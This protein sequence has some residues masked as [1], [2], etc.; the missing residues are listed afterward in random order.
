LTTLFLFGFGRNSWPWIVVLW[1][2][3]AIVNFFLF[4]KVP[5][6]PPIPEEHRQGMKMLILKPF[7]IVAFLA[8]LAGGASELVMSQWSSAFMEKAMLLPKVVG[9]VAGMTMFALMLG[10][11]R[12]LYGIYGTK[13]NVIRM[14]MAGSILAIACYL[15]VAFSPYN[16]LSLI[17]CAV[18]GFAVCLL[19]PGTLVIAAERFP[20]AGAWLFAILAAGGDIGASIGPWFMSVVTEHGPKLAIFAGWSGSLGL[21]VEQLGLRMGMFS[22]ALFP[23]GA[24]LCM[25][26]MVRARKKGILSEGKHTAAVKDDAIP[27]L[28]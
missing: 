15:V 13:I 16:V 26:W 23:L 19:W 28:S 7:F 14:M 27:D 9:D 2:I 4:M 6:A 24:L 5:L 12:L 22:G 3:P 17:A 11:G 20:L 18:C 8:L 1:T 21:S 25:V 10:V